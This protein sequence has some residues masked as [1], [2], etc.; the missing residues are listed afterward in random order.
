MRVYLV[1]HAKASRDP[2]IATDEERPLTE[3]GRTDAE[4]VAALV[5]A[6]GA[7][8]AQIRHSGLLRAEQTAQIF[9]RHLL[10]PEGVVAV[11]GLL[12]DDPVETWA[13]RLAGETSPVMLVGHNPFM[14]ALVALLLGVE[15]SHAPIRFA[16][17]SVACLENAEGA[18]SLKWLLHRELAARGSGE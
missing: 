16:T 4:A 13:V 12:W 8:V 5:A 1:R 15:P 2:A 17:S 3:R 9:A 7:P 10:P 6:A 18:W 14:E 11:E